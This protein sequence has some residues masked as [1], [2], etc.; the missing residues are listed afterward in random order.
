MYFNI[1]QSIRHFVWFYSNMRPSPYNT[2]QKFRIKFVIPD[3]SRK[4]MPKQVD[5]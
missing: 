3:T 4:K 1:A 5:L 2:S